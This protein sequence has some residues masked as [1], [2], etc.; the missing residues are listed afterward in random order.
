LGFLDP[1]RFAR[2]EYK[3]TVL[4]F[5]NLGLHGRAQWVIDL[6][7]GWLSQPPRAGFVQKKPYKGKVTVE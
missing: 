5:K 7:K 3:E 4:F 6:A 1:E 2:A